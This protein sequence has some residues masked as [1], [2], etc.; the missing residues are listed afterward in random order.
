MLSLNKVQLAGNVGEDPSIKTMQ[1][2]DRVANLSIATKESWKDKESGEWKEKTEWSRVV[3]FNQASVNFVEKHVKKGSQ[4]YVEGK[5]ETRSY[6]SNGE[7]KYTTEVV[8]RPYG[9]EVQ[10]IDK[11]ESA[12]NGGGNGRGQSSD[13]DYSRRDVGEDEIPFNGR[14]GQSGPA[15]RR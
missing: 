14:R 12:N 1:S 7:K 4:V 6:E 10:L 5:L 2:G 9:G 11:F 13:R 8:V 3:V 15:P